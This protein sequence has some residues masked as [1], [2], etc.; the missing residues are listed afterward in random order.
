MLNSL[1]VA[2]LLLAPA[3]EVVQQHVVVLSLADPHTDKEIHSLLKPHVVRGFVWHMSTTLHADG[4]WEERYRVEVETTS[5]LS[6]LL[7]D[8]QKHGSRAT[9]FAGSDSLQ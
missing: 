5:T 8:L 7:R 6:E 2:V 9:A 1:L 4:T 3:P